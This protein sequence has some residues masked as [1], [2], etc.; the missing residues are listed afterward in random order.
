MKLNVVSLETAKRLQSAGFAKSAASC[1]WV[2]NKVNGEWSV[3]VDAGIN[4][5][6]FAA[7]TAQELADQLPN[8]TI[9]H[10]Q[11]D[12]RFMADD[13]VPWSDNVAWASTMAE[14]LAALWLKLR[15]NANI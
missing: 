9:I 15:E 5:V 7:P 6:G 2:E 13:G 8:R 11:D 14:A 3:R 10:K 1:R 12:R 4:Y